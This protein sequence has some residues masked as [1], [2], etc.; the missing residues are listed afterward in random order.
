MVGFWI[1]GDAGGGGR[2]ADR[3]AVVGT[4]GSMVDQHVEDK[5]TLGE[6]EKDLERYLTT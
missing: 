2:A 1:C 5:D 3:V 4:R 6:E